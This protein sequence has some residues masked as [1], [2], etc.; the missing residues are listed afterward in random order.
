MPVVVYIHGGGFA[1]GD[2][3]G[4]LQ[5]LE[6]LAQRGYFALTINYR[7]GFGIF[8]AQIEDVKT[9]IRFLRAHGTEYGI[10]DARIGVW[11]VSA[12]GTL[13]TLA[14]TAGDATQWDPSAGSLG[15]PSRVAAV[16][17]WF[18]ASNFLSASS[19]GTETTT[20]LG[21]PTSTCRDLAARP[22]PVTYV[23]GDDPPFLVMAGA[24]EQQSRELVSA[25]NTAGVSAT[26][27]L[28]GRE[29]NVPPSAIAAAEAF[30]DSVLR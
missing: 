27:N 5:E 17:T 23:T 14:G 16:V 28:D 11:G 20:F 8:P 1:S 18:G 25:L 2:K 21:C 29:G 22:S 30:L 15:F 24:C 10:N 4:G 26:L 7:L 19:C 6:S 9:A 3:S 12:G 13:A